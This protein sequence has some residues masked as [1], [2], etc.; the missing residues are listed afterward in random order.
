MGSHSNNKLIPLYRWFSLFLNIEHVARVCNL[1]WI[2]KK[3][4]IFSVA[5]HLRLDEIHLS[6]R[7]DAIY[8]KSKLK[9]KQ[10]RLK[11]EWW[12]ID[13][14]GIGTSAWTFCWC[15]TCTATAT[16][17]TFRSWAALWMGCSTVRP[18]TWR[19]RSWTRCTRICEWTKK[20]MSL[21][22]LL[23][24]FN[25]R[26]KIDAYGFDFYPNRFD[27]MWHFRY[28]I[29][30]LKLEFCAFRDLIKHFKKREIE[31]YMYVYRFWSIVWFDAML[32]Y[33]CESVTFESATGI[34]CLL[35]AIDKNDI[36]FDQ[37]DYSN[38]FTY[39]YD[40]CPSHFDGM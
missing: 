38:I 25:H 17:T 40:F 32:V 24:Y 15:L 27:G 5:K 11:F 1:F 30:N 13:L 16:S 2:K 22:F 34:Y 37:T 23:D 19:A 21:N 35:N 26:K 10:N 12:M 3:N 14:F 9:C 33:H 6:Y 29:V 18:W 28:A 4:S 31:K 20:C 39:H 7:A 36:K 8:L